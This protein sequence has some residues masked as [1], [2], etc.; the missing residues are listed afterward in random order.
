MTLI[1][2]FNY[3]S[4]LNLVFTFMNLTINYIQIKVLCYYLHNQ[5]IH[6]YATILHTMI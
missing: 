5:I 1:I 2:D 4:V 6:L 3:L